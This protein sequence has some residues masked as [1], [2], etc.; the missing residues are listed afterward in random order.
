MGI[1]SDPFWFRV[2][3]NLLN[4][5]IRD[6]GLIIAKQEQL[7]RHEVNFIEGFS[8]TGVFDLRDC[9]LQVAS[10]EYR[11]PDEDYLTDNNGNRWLYYEPANYFRQHY[12]RNRVSLTR[13]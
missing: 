3:K 6:V 2:C 13:Y 7:N 10:G 9:N 8:Q 12:P 5:S 4:Y 1:Y 11:Y